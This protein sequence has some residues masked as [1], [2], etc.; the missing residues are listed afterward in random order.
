MSIFDRLSNP[1]NFTGMYKQRFRPENDE[2]EAVHDLSEI[3]RTPTPKKRNSRKRVKSATP[4]TRVYPVRSPKR[5]TPARDRPENSIFDRLSNP[6]T[7]TGTHSV[8]RKPRP[9]AVHD[10]SA[11]MRPDFKTPSKVRERRR[12]EPKKPDIWLTK[13][14]VPQ[15]SVFSRLTDHKTYNSTHKHRFDRSGKGRGKIGRVTENGAVHHLSQITRTY[16][17]KNKM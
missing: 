10:L 15:D 14:E 5:I 7:F 17:G 9:K 3:L 1:N 11:I 13:P 4:K 2:K 12:R 16:L 8:D 6:H